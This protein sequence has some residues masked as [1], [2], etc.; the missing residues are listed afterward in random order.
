MLVTRR[1]VSLGDLLKNFGVKFGG[2]VNGFLLYVTVSQARIDRC[3]LSRSI[4]S[5]D[6][7]LG[8]RCFGY[9]PTQ[10]FWQ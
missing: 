10:F 8:C 1:K 6:D 4:F 5:V 7:N 3:R 9:Q 2:S